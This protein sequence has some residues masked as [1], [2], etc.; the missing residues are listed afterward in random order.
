MATKKNSTSQD[1]N[2]EK[3]LS[4]GQDSSDPNR[5][6]DEDSLDTRNVASDV[7]EGDEDYDDEE[8]DD[9]EL[10]ED[11]FEV[12]DTEEDVDEDEDVE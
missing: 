3:T 5:V 1:L 6:N 8:L 2:E 7:E 12:D 9:D 11:D 4:R 10:D